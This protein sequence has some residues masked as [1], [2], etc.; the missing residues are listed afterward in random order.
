MKERRSCMS[1]QLAKAG[2]FAHLSRKII[3]SY[4]VNSIEK[5]SY[6][7][8]AEEAQIY[9]LKLL[10]E[11]IDNYIARTKQN[12]QVNLEK[13]LWE[14]V[15]VLEDQHTFDDV[16]KLAQY[17]KEK[18]GWQHVNMAIHRDEGHLDEMTGEIVYNYHAHIIFLMLNKKGIYVFKKREFGKKKMSVLQT[19][20]ANKLNMKR[21]E[22][23]LKTGNEH[24]APKIFR[25]VAKEIDDLKFELKRISG[26]ADNFLEMWL[27]E[28]EE[29][30]QYEKDII[31]LKAKV[32]IRDSRIKELEELI[33]D[34][35][36]SED[37]LMDS[38]EPNDDLITKLKIQVK[39]LEN[40]NI[41][42]R[43]SLGINEISSG[44]SM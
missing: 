36:V 42:L 39:N 34:S 15:F 17:F 8:D 11:A 5:N 20:V 7:L 35:N 38:I 6:D 25:K 44:M 29:R 13:L 41:E 14:A 3:P 40:E 28:K 23:K 37:S 12:I 10:N 27:A 1:I 26:E 2:C 24:I 31:Q 16:K 30:M 18:Y 9:Y 19:E 43:N 33:E 32:S 22:S 4:L 21:G